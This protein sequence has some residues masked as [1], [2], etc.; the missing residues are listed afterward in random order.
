[1]H[2]VQAVEIAVFESSRA[3]V[4]AQVPLERLTS[5]RRA[6][7]GLGRF[8]LV[9]LVAAGVTL[10]PLLHLCGATALVLLAPL[11]GYLAWRP[12]V[13]LAPAAL[14]CPKCGA[15]VTVRGGTPGWPAR[16]HC[17][18]CGAGLVARPAR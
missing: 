17:E 13:L 6:A 11:A 8:A 1:M 9:S 10:V 3:A 2:E 7:R 18:G 5:A 4:R 14:P 16:L 12:T 15:P